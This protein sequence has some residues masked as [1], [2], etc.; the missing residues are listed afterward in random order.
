M[1]A[2]TGNLKLETGNLKL[3][4]G[5]LKLE[6]GNLKRG[7]GSLKRG[8]GNLK[9]ETGDLLNWGKRKALETSESRG[10]RA[11]AGQMEMRLVE[12][13]RA[14]EQYRIVPAPWFEKQFGW[15]ERTCRAIAEASDGQILG[16]SAGY[17]LTIQASVEEFNAA[18]SRIY[19]QGKK[20][21]RR[22]IR[23]RRVRHEL[24]GE[25]K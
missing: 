15:S 19:S 3:E 14:L 20:M 11:D 18:N 9:A 17:C 2:E 6:T 12:M 23:E 4:T 5:N 21:L 13:K 7:T 10:Q 24:I 8:T 25:R 22:A 16:T 1:K